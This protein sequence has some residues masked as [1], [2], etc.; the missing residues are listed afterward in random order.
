MTLETLDFTGVSEGY[1]ENGKPERLGIYTLR[2]YAIY[3]ESIL[4]KMESPRDWAFTHSNN[5]DKIFLIP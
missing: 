3:I 5:F 2:I 4:V 1:R